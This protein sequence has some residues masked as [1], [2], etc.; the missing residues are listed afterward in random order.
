[1]LFNY[2][3]FYRTILNNAFSSSE[4]RMLFAVTEEEAERLRSM[5][6]DDLIEKK[7]IRLV[8]ELISEDG[9]SCFAMADAD[10]SGMSS[11]NWTF[12]CKTEDKLLSDGSDRLD[13]QA[14]VAGIATVGVEGLEEIGSRDIPLGDELLAKLICF[15]KSLF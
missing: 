10:F 3:D 12:V 15:Q 4:N 13:K 6:L 2:E 8:Q 5:T 14:E 9:P 11:F 7:Y 1:M